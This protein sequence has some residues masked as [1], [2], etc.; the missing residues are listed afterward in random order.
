M[1][2]RSAA[3]TATTVIFWAVGR[4]CHFARSVAPCGMVRPLWAP[5]PCGAGGERGGKSAGPPGPPAEIGGGGPGGGG[6]GGGAYCG[7]SGSGGRR[8]RPPL[9]GTGRG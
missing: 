3:M 4:P 8:G 5:A 9:V 7:G 6:G 2:P 1:A